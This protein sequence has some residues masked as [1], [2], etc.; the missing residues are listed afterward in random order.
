MHQEQ[1]PSCNYYTILYMIRFRNLQK[2]VSSTK[3]FHFEIIK[4]NAL[5]TLW[6]L[7][8]LMIRFLLGNKVH[9]LILRWSVV[10]ST[11]T[12]TLSN[13]TL[14]RITI[15][16]SSSSLSLFIIARKFILIFLWPLVLQL[17]HNTGVP[18]QHST[19]EVIIGGFLQFASTSLYSTGSY[20]S[21]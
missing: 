12:K 14:R 4:A 10:W 11:G 16:D 8:V 9:T 6:K 3:Y 1:S 7:M 20:E 19:F 15:T 17:C 2:S 5:L 13:A 21:F 18:T